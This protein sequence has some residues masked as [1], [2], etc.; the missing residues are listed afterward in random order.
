MERWKIRTSLP[1]IKNVKNAVK[2]SNEGGLSIMF[3]LRFSLLFPISPPS[4][5]SL[6][7][8]IKK[9]RNVNKR[10]IQQDERTDD[11]GV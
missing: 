7:K 4:F 9:D 5:E 6:L 3:F 2:G 11:A 1:Y 8:H 10:T